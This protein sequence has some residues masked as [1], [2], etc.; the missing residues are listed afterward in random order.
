MVMYKHPSCAHEQR[1][2]KAR[3][4]KANARQGKAGQGK[5]GR[6]GAGQGKAQARSSHWWRAW[7]PCCFSP[8]LMLL[9]AHQA[10]DWSGFSA[11]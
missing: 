7:R 5:A 10:S 8:G 1:Q 4:G 9:P 11:R 2:G 6:G 3:Q